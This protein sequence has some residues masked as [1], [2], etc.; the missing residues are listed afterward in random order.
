M[1]NGVTVFN[2]IMFTF[3]NKTSLLRAM[4]QKCRN[5]SSVMILF[6]SLHFI[7]GN[8]IFQRDY[9]E[10]TKCDKC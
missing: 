2:G 4:P 1:D 7:Q 9:L 3:I 5:H 6:L 8:L 10:L